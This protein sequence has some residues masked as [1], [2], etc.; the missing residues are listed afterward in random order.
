M[1]VKKNTNCPRV[2]HI[3]SGDLWAGAEAQLFTL[4]KALHC[5]TD[6]SVSVVLLNHGKLENQL[7]SIGINTTVLDKSRL[8]VLNIMRQIIHTIREQR[9]DIIHTHRTKENI[10]GSFAAF[11]AGRVP[12]LR[13]AH[14]AT[15]RCPSWWEIPKRLINALDWF[16]GRFMQQKV[17]AVSEDLSNILKKNTHQVLSVS[18]KMV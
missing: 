12:S 2:L 1:P 11:F 10:L 7:R 9:P 15:E 5:K 18:L 6:V 16:C 17:I 13:T 8:N 3:A 4:A 14:G